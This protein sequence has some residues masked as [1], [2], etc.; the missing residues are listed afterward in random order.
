MKKT[1]NNQKTAGSKIPVERHVS[2]IVDFL[3]NDKPIIDFG[4][5]TADEFEKRIEEAWNKPTAYWH[6][7]WKNNKLCIVVDR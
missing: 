6:Y 7:E 5:M 4:Q 3:K 2:G 1:K